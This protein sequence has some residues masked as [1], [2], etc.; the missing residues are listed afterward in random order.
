MLKLISSTDRE[1]LVISIDP[2]VALE[3]DDREPV[4]AI[5]KRSCT[6]NGSTP[7]VFT[8]RPLKSREMIRVINASGVSATE[9]LVR[10]AEIGLTAIT[11]ENLSATKPTEVFET[12]D[13]LPHSAI[14]A[15][16]AYLIEMS[17]LP[18]DPTEPDELEPPLG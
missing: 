17:G 14:L 4:R 10:A 9:G 1:D 5:S 3:K 11:G 16:G 7:T 15:V 12:I 6:L 2:A 13:L 18:E 8:I